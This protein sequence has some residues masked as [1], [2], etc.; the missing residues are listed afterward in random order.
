M[1]ARLWSTVAKL[2]PGL[3]HNWLARRHDGHLHLF[4]TTKWPEAQMCIRC[5]GMRFRSDND[6]VF[7]RFIPFF[8]WH[9]C[10]GNGA[11]RQLGLIQRTS[12]LGLQAVHMFLRAPG[13]LPEERPSWRV[14]LNWVQYVPGIPME[15]YQV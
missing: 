6:P 1:T 10:D 15:S 3:R 8:A 12:P 14:P 13:E 5:G 2:R 9:Y 7:F 4:G 11:G